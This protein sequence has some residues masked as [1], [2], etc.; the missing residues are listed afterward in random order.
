M[1][2]FGKSAAIFLNRSNEASR[3]V[4]CRSPFLR[5]SAVCFFPEDRD[6]CQAVSLSGAGGVKGRGLAD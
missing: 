1:L 5:M 4:D 2:L 6:L 3:T